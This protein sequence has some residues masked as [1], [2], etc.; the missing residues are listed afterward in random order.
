M[1]FTFIPFERVGKILFGMNRQTVRKIIKL[2]FVEV[3]RS[4]YEESK[5]DFFPRLEIFIEYNSDDLCEAVEFT[6]GSKII[7]NDINLMSLSFKSLLN[8]FSKIST[9]NEFEGDYGVTYYDIGFS[10]SKHQVDGSIETILAFSK[11]YWDED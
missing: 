8:Q 7:F 3:Q 6:T 11:T 1:K 2:P 5:S 9:E 4:P 10:V